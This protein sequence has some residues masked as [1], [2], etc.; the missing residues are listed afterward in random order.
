M[1]SR[2]NGTTESTENQESKAAKEGVKL[3]QTRDPGELNTFSQDGIW[4]EIKYSVDSGA[5]ESV[6][7]EDMPKSIPTTQGAACKRGVEY[8]VANGV[9][10]PNE[11]EKRF[12]AVTEEG[13]E[14]NMVVQVCDV[15]QGLLS[16]SK[17]V[18]A[19]NRVVFDGDGSY[20]ENKTSKKIVKIEKVQGGYLLNLWVKKVEMQ[21]VNSL[22][23]FAN[24][25]SSFARLGQLI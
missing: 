22:S 8:E 25:N 17:A 13:K 6:T 4:E 19:G 24:S 14:K 3:I 12:T 18:A 2:Q 9:S 16:V 23:E 11:G 7:P 10:I 5:T 1:E 15:N 21:E 20:I